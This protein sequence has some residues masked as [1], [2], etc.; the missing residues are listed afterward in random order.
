MIPLNLVFNLQFS[1]F[2]ISKYIA[3]R[4]HTGLWGL[5][6]YTFFKLEA[7]MFAS[8]AVQVWRYFIGLADTFQD[9][10]GALPMHFSGVQVVAMLL[11]TW[12]FV[13][14]DVTVDTLVRRREFG[15]QREVS[16]VNFVVHFVR[17]FPTL[18]FIEVKRLFRVW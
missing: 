6:L 17:F 7:D 1:K 8:L 10:A 18:H 14:W 2:D 3:I 12:N 4:L 13:K 11:S 9:D 15:E 5:S 16:T